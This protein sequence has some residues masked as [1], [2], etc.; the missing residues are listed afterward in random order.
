MFFFVLEKKSLSD[1]LSIKYF[2]KSF[3][4]SLKD[5]ALLSLGPLN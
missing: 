2:V 5:S 3:L 4:F 1:Q